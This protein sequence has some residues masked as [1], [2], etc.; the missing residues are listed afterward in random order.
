MF[1]WIKKRR[2][3]KILAAPFPKKWEQ[4]LNQNV[5]QFKNLSSSQRRKLIECVKIIV[6]ESI[7][8]GCDDLVLHDEI[9]VTIAG[10]ASLLLLG[11]SNYFFDTVSTI[12]VFPHSVQRE[13]YDGLV[14]DEHQHNLGEAYQ[15][16]QI[17]L[18]W[19]DVLAGGRYDD[20]HNLVIHEFAHHVDGLD[21]EMAGLITFDDPVDTQNWQRVS[22]REFE[23]LFHARE[24]NRRTL[25]DHYGATSMAEFFA[26]ATEAFIEKP[27]ELNRQYQELYELLK[28]FYKVDPLEWV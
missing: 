5:Y 14:I 8:E 28:K 24:Q 20:G 21:G 16:G 23:S 13:A 25:L 12:L 3:R 18:S 1:G 4:T 15:T 2:R 11:T 6:A 27:R 17:V 9:K 10:Q 22:K 19:P 26:V 7:F